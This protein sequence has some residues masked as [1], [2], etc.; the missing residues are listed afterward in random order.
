VAVIPYLGTAPQIAPGSFIAPDAWVTGRVVIEDRVTIL[1]GAALRGDINAIHVG[2][3]TNIQEHAV[4]HTSHGLGDCRVGK[5]V[6]VGHHA[7][8]HG[9]T[10]RDRCI[11]G[12]GSTILDGAEIGEDCIIGAN[13]LVPMNMKI[14]PKSLAV[15]VPAKVMRTLS[16]EEVRSILQSAASYQEVGRTY[17][18]NLG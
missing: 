11:I 17:K 2:E 9:C 7:I 3:G 18:E 5:N 16:E 1:F 12:M 10:V 4:L 6:T 8:V 14:P 13:A 15:G